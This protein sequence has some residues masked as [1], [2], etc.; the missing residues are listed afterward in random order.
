MYIYI[1]Q[2]CA[3]TDLKSGDKF[4]AVFF[5]RLQ[6]IN[7]FNSEKNYWNR[8]IFAIARVSGKGKDKPITIVRAI[9]RNTTSWP[10]VYMFSVAAPALRNSLPIDVVDANT[11]LSFKKHLKTHLYQRAYLT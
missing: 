4:Y 9:N 10:T 2:G 11:L 5:R 6:F 8:F 1:S 7:D 3:A